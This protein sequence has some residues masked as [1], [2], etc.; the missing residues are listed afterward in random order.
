MFFVMFNLIKLISVFK[1]D[2][3][4]KVTETEDKKK[5]KIKYYFR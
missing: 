4:Y 1:R 3:P 2:I 5:K